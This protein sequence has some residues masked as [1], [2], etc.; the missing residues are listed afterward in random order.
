[1]NQ[2]TDLTDLGRVKEK[3]RIERDKRMR[4]EGNKQ[5]V[6]VSHDNLSHYINDPYV[7]KPIERTPCNDEIEVVIVGGGF[8]A[9]LAGAELRNAGF[10]ASEI[11]LIEK[12]GDFGGTWYWN[13]YP[14]AACDIESYIYLPKL[15]ETGYM[16]VEKY[17]RAPEILEHSKRI[18][19]QYDLYDN[20]LLQ[21]EVMEMQWQS[22]KQ[23][24]LVTTNKGDAMLARYVLMSNGPMHRP[25]MPQVPGLDSFQGH[26]FHTSR[27]DYQYTGGDTT[28]NLSR[29][30]DK[31]VGI[32]GTGATAVQC[33]PHLAQGAKELYVFQRTPSS[34]DVR[35]D[36][37]TD[38]AWAQSLQPG[39]HKHRMENFNNLVTGLPEKEDLVADGW[40]DIIR[41][42]ATMFMNGEVKADSIE[43]LNTLMEQADVEKMNQIR[44]RVDDV[45]QDPTV[46]EHLKPWYRQFCKRPCFHDDY[47][48][49]FNQ[50]NVHLID[51]D[52]AG[53]DNITE[54]GVIAN[55]K[56]Y[57]LDCLIFATGFVVGGDLHTRVPA[58]AY[59]VIG[60]GGESLVQA[61]SEGI[62]SIHGMTVHNFPNCFIF[63]GL[64]GGF[65]ANYPHNLQEQAEHVAYILNRARTDNATIVE[66][67]K[68][69]EQQ[70]VATI[71][72]K[73]RTREQFLAEC[74]PG[75]YNNEGIV[76]PTA[77]R[78]SFYGGGSPE[79]F[80]L[81]EQWREQ[82]KLEG[83]EL[84]S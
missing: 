62:R 55:G 4:T 56:E 43:Q 1:M 20:C 82:D 74:T 66:A 40:T 23:R 31:R 73:A 33:V 61:W 38:P 42:L 67:E 59:P 81:L 7:E 68:E 24:W 53:I 72:E 25:K 18:A 47:L 30:K 45:I 8:G 2:K 28:G 57:Q 6:E 34:I 65:T 9:L 46:A 49:S 39:W 19:E 60:R 48:V 27:W 10:D 12:G 16:P 36:K 51:T 29:L 13:R 83:L 15:E 17:S 22:D 71:E 44:A 50:P 80:K 5:Y 35:G 64:Q 21:T 79:Y 78:N 14:G 63:G 52:G 54:Q 76:N 58:P 41:N 84:T 75:Y 69:A 11:R 3:Y 32:L 26:S 70:W 37:P 77:R